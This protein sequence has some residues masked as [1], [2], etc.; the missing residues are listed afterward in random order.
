MCDFLFLFWYPPGFLVNLIHHKSLQNLFYGCASGL[1]HIFYPL[2]GLLADIKVGRHRTITIST[3]LLA[4]AL[5]VSIIALCIAAVAEKLDFWS[6]DV[7]EVAVVVLSAIAWVPLTIGMVGLNANSIQYGV[8]QLTDSPREDQSIFILWQVWIRYFAELLF[9]AYYY[10]L[11]ID[12]NQEEHLINKLTLGASLVILLVLT[13]VLAC[14]LAHHQEWFIV[15]ERRINPYRL[16]YKVT[17]FARQ[18]K[19]PVNRSAFTYCEDEIPSGLDLAKTKYGGPFS[20]EEVENVKAFYGI[21]KVILASSFMVV[22]Y[23]NL[24]TPDSFQNHL[25]SYHPP[26]NFSV[27]DAV[28]V[29]ALENISVLVIPLYI[30]LLRPFI[31]YYIPSMLKRVGVAMLVPLL[32]V[33]VLLA[34]D[35]LVHAEDHT[36]YCMFESPGGPANGTTKPPPQVSLYFSDG[37]HYW[38][39]ISV[40]LNNLSRYIYLVASF[41]FICS[42]SPH[43]MKGFLIGV[44]FAIRGLATVFYSV[45]VTVVHFSWNHT[46][47]PSCGMV[48]YFTLVLIGLVSA[49]SYVCVARSYRYRIRDEPCHVYRYVED[50]YSNIQTEE[51]Y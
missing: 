43:S 27:L 4:V 32:L 41:E 47:F 51:N 13:L 34:G 23:D 45:L 18:H 35:T 31:S 30:L 50:Y 49:V 39:T 17:Q 37:F 36:L 26:S 12:L 1:L 33:L 48:F 20:T 6:S 28:Q 22:L 2:A 19:V 15:E 10:F 11:H 21:F 8:D 38:V 42:Q 5:V 14:L 25:T 7:Y 44:A 9:G 24:N 16:M 40:T 46:T 3:Q 29:T